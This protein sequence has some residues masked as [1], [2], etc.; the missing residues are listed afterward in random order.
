VQQH[1]LHVACALWPGSGLDTEASGLCCR[2]HSTVRLSLGCAAR[3]L[4]QPEFEATAQRRK[5][6]GS[7]GVGEQLAKAVHQ[8]CEVQPLCLGVRQPARLH[9]HDSS[10]R[11]VFSFPAS[12]RLFGSTAHQIAITCGR[13]ALH[14]Q[15]AQATRQ[16]VTPLRVQERMRGPAH[17]FLE[18]LRRCGAPRRSG[19]RARRG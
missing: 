16:S 3:G 6:E 11:R 18:G 12:L 19:R 9:T 7:H 17:R 10:I 1:T 4:S 8:A 13:N 14:S 2:C 5:G 15:G